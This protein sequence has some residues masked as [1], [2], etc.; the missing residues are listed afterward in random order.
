MKFGNQYYLDP[1]TWTS[2]APLALGS[3][4]L[5]K[6]LLQFSRCRHRVC[7][8]GVDMCRSICLSTSQPCKIGNLGTTLLPAKDEQWP[9]AG[10]NTAAHIRM[11]ASDVCCCIL[12]VECLAGSGD[13]SL[14]L[15]YL[16]SRW[17]CHPLMQIGAAAHKESSA[18]KRGEDLLL[19]GFK[20]Y[21]GSGTKL[22]L[23]QCLQKWL[24]YSSVYPCCHTASR[25]QRRLQRRR[26]W[27][28]CG[29]G[30]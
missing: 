29:S 15:P 24:L 6:S 22:C 9:P 1:G 11:K 20:H 28:R 3:T 23:P 8:V 21:S 26:G 5:G 13:Q 4:V 2:I 12:L 16:R 30:M 19:P 17:R 27:S 10:P 7:W 14:W 18:D 25:R